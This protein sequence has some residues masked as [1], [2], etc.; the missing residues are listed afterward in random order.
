MFVHLNGEIVPESEAV[1]PVSDRGFMYG[2]GVFETI[3]VHKGMTLRWFA[4]MDR[5]RSGLEQLEIP[6]QLDTRTLHE[7]ARELIEQN[8]LSDA[9]LRVQITRGPG[10]RGYSPKGADSPTIVITAHTAPPLIEAQP[11]WS[12]AESSV[13]IQSDNPLTSVKSLN[14]LP[15]ILAKA[16][17][18]R[19]DCNDAVLLN[20]RSEVAEATCANIFWMRDG[21]VFTPPLE[22]GALPGVTRN[23]V[24]DLA[25][26]GEIELKETPTTMADLR[27][28]E[29][30]FL[31]L[32]SLVL[33]EVDAIGG[34]PIP[35][36]PIFA[37][38][39]EGF[40]YFLNKGQGLS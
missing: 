14:K 19:A 1:V 3:R 10:K 16:E 24:S 21:K 39:R 5:L 25:A 28:A 9:V 32:S 4:H 8:Q 29:G 37:R 15:N 31:S 17:A 34:N 36:S 20:E 13:R 2:D 27:E 12:L 38:L 40:L 33:V 35:T 18:D 6:Y 11:R 26:M 7:S 30:I 22:S 23:F